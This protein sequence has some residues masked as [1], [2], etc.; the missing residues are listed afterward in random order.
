MESR[1]KGPAPGAVRTPK[2]GG[3]RRGGTVALT[4]LATLAQ[5]GCNDS[6]PDRVIST[7]PREAIVTVHAVLLLPPPSEALIPELHDYFEALSAR[8]ATGEIPPMWAAY[9]YINY[10]RDLVR[11]RPDGLPRRTLEEVRGDLDANV[12]FYSIRKRPDVP[13]SPI[14]AWVWQ[15]APP[16]PIGP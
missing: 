10:Y 2:L 11:D 14:G 12:E 3:L 13:P 8:A 16:A 7:D 4:A 9:L 1:L 6:P 5:V 15:A